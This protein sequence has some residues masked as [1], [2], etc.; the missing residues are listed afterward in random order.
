MLKYLRGL[1]SSGWPSGGVGKSCSRKS[2]PVYSFER[3]ELGDVNEKWFGFAYLSEEP[4][5]FEGPEA[6]ERVEKKRVRVRDPVT[7]KIAHIFTIY[8]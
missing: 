6:W 8:F 1:F 7:L 4:E 3:M 2:W 5:G